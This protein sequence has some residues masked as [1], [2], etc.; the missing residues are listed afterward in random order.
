MYGVDIGGTNTEFAAFDHDLTQRYTRRIATPTRDY[1]QLVRSIGKLVE[2]ADAQFRGVDAIGVGVPGIRDRQD[3][4]FS[5]NVP[6]ITGRNVKDDL[7]SALNRTVAVINDGRAFALSET[8]G[9][10]GQGHDPMV[11]VILGT[12]VFG[13]YCIGGNL[14]G[15]RDGWPASGGIFRSRPRSGIAI[16]CH[17]N[18]A[19][20]ASGV[21]LKL[22]SPAAGYRNC[23]LTLPD[24]P[25]PPSDSSSGC[26]RAR[27]RASARSVSGSIALRTASFSSSFTSIRR[28]SSWVGGCPRL[29]NST[30]GCRRPCRSTCTGD[31][32]RRVSCRPGLVIPAAH[33]V[34]RFLQHNSI[35]IGPVE[36]HLPDP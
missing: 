11:G 24:Q 28:S 36:A 1:D 2:E 18:R 35:V 14:Q 5:V 23:M 33:A 15:G 8:H 9:G 7:G 13:G 32:D 31:C 19:A 10:A 17:C 27:R 4:S 30:P 6:C 34:P 3:L 29:G 12:G 22:T 20:V 25:F 16:H 26:A 21:V